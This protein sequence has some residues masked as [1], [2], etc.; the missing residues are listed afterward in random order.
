MVHIILGI[1]YFKSTKKQL[2]LQ[3][4][5]NVIYALHFGKYASHRLHNEGYDSQKNLFNKY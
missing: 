4:R 2:S 1:N 5:A 3:Q